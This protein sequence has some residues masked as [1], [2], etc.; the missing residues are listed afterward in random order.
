MKYALF[1]TGSLEDFRPGANWVSQRLVQ[2]SQSTTGRINRRSALSRPTLL[3][4][5]GR[6][7]SLIVRA[8]LAAGV[9]GLILALAVNLRHVNTTTIALVLVLAVLCIAM[10]WGW[11]EAMVAAIVA[12]LG[13]AYF[14]LPPQGFAIEQPEHLVAFL[15]FLITALAAGHLSARANRHRAE[16]IKRREEIEKLFQVADVISQGENREAILQRLG[17]ALS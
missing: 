7:I 10:T 17:G 14:F 1:G 15:A 13:L 5:A 8:S 9:V 2:G 6:V 4:G 11:L 16:A 3:T 12:G